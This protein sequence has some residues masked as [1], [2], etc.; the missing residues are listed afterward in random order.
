MMRRPNDDG[1]A[2]HA[3]HPQY[4]VQTGALYLAAKL[5]AMQGACAVGVQRLDLGSDDVMLDKVLAHQELVLRLPPSLWQRR[6]WQVLAT[7]MLERERRAAVPYGHLAC[8]TSPPNIPRHFR[9]G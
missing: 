2:A 6:D 9:A 3:L 7:G 5:D 8:N 4:Q 1:N